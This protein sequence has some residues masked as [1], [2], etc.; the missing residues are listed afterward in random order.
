MAWLEDIYAEPDAP[1]KL[2]IVDTIS[3]IVFTGKVLLRV[4]EVDIDVVKKLIEER[5]GFES[6]I[7][8]PII[9]LELADMLGYPIPRSS[10]RSLELQRD[11][12]IVVLSPRL[13]LIETLLIET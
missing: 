11:M 10:R 1:K 12:N 9:A 5:R 3:K 6:L 4:A 7:E 2:Y 13:L 8:D